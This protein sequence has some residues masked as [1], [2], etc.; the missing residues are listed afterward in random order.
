VKENLTPWI[1]L[2]AEKLL[3]IFAG[4]AIVYGSINASLP[5]RRSNCLAKLSEH[6]A[7]PQEH[8]CRRDTP[9]VKFDVSLLCLSS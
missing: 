4:G 1:S 7:F 8:R 9:Q 6:V 2:G 3:Q 5:G